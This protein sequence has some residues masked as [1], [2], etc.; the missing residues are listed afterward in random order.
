M[1]PLISFCSRIHH[2][3]I[4]IDEKC[5]FVLNEK[6]MDTE[7]VLCDMKQTSD[8]P[9]QAIR[10]LSDKLSEIITEAHTHND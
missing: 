6:Q 7:K 1:N 2:I 5:P 4:T 3:L 10:Q 9:E 8:K